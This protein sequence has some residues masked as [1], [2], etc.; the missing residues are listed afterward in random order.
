MEWRL[1]VLMLAALAF[2]PVATGTSR[3]SLVAH[4]PL[5]ETS[6]TVA[7]DAAGRN[8]ATLYGSPVWESAKVRPGGSLLFDGKDDYMTAGF[9]LDP[10]K[11]PFSAFAWVLG[12]EAGTI[13]IAQQDFGGT[14]QA[15]LVAGTTSGKLGTE[16]TDTR[17]QVRALQADAV[18][19]DGRWHHVGV[20][21]DGQYRRLYL[22][23]EEVAADQMALVDMRS[24][25]GGLVIGASKTQDRSALWPVSNPNARPS[26]RC[27]WLPPRRSIQAL[28]RP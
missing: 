4:W 24:S 12:N 15:W 6:G 21:W 8:N 13:V 27:W 23:G 3:A 20:V 2:V 14:G 18:V 28:R 22:D 17:G 10:A 25:L 11:S 16:L 7:A 1:R 19:A 9:V 26:R 5:D